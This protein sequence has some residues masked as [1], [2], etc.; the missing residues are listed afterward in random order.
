MTVKRTM[1]E[2]VVKWKVLVYL[3]FLIV[4]FVP[5]VE[6]FVPHSILEMGAANHTK[7]W[8]QG[9]LMIPTQL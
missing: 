9:S 4:L 7:G 3:T 6:V 1:K 2:Q 5:E 8:L